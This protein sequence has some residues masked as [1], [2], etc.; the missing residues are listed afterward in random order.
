MTMEQLQLTVLVDFLLI[1]KEIS[2]KKGITYYTN[3]QVISGTAINSKEEGKIFLK[4]R[5]AQGKYLHE[6]SFNEDIYQDDISS[7]GFWIHVNAVFTNA[8]IKIWTSTEK[9][10]FVPHQSQSVI[11]PIQQEMLSGDYISDVEHHEWG[12]VVLTGDESFNLDSTYQGIAQFSLFKNAKWLNDNIIRA[13]SNHFKGVQ[14]NG[15]WTKDNTIT[16]I[17]GGNIR[18][19]TSKYTT[20]EDF[21]AMLKSKY[22]AGTPVIIYYKLATSVDLALTDEQKK[23]KI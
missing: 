1:S 16:T 11:M 22:E 13:I 19:M 21:K 23:H 15:S 5:N 7:S 3:Y 10:D 17:G 14:F 20:I 8:K 6:N 4:L 12:K 2:L 18:M 9:S